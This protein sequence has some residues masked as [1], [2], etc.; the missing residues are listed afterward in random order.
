MLPGP[1]VPA[2]TPEPAGE[3]GLA[4]GGQRRA[5][6]VAH[7]DPFDLAAAHRI[8]KRIEEVADQGEDLADP[9]LFERADEDV[10]DSFGHLDL[11]RFDGGVR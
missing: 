5:L 6:L 3:L 2:Q 9:D 10:R 7:A 11:L 4:G 1:V 8:G